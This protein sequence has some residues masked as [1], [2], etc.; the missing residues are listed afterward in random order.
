[1]QRPVSVSFWRPI[2]GLLV[3]LIAVSQLGAPRLGAQEDDETR[4]AWNRAVPPVRIVGDLYHVGAAEVASF[5]IVSRRGCALIDGGLPE[6]APQVISNLPALGIRPK[7]VRWLFSTHAHFDHAGGLAELKARTGATFAALAQEQPLLERGGLGDPNFGD[8][9]YFSAV[10]IDR[11]LRDKERIEVGNVTLVAHHTPGHTPGNTSWE[12][13]QKIDGKIVRAVIVGS[14]SAPGYKLV[15]NAAYPDI[16]QDYRRSFVRLRAL[17]NQ[18]T[19]VFLGAHGSFFDFESK[20]ARLAASPS[21]PNPFIDREALG[22][23][24]DRYEREFE[25]KLAK[26]SATNVR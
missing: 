13:I 5:L 17:A 14:L 24:V 6:T 23:H 19:D 16:V 1:M 3:A 22:R 18:G 12:V 7:Q 9:F 11:L 21:G 20:R 26:Q 8:S 10:R 15:G 25:E 4:R 2:G